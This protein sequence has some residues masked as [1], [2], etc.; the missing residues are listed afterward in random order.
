MIALL[1]L[2]S[3]SAP[4]AVNSTGSPTFAPKGGLMYSSNALIATDSSG[5]KQAFVSGGIGVDAF[6]P[7][8]HKGLDKLDVVEKEASYDIVDA[9][10]ALLG[11]G[12][13]LAP[14]GK[15]LFAL[16][17]LDKFLIGSHKFKFVFKSTVPMFKNVVDT[18]GGA[19]SATPTGELDVPKRDGERAYH[20][21][22]PTSAVPHLAGGA[23]LV[24]GRGFD[25]TG[26]M[27]LKQTAMWVNLSTW[28]GAGSEMVVALNSS[29]SMPYAF[30]G[31]AVHAVGSSVYVVGG[32]TDTNLG[33]V[34]TACHQLDLAK[35]D[36]NEVTGAAARAT[37]AGRA[38]QRPRAAS[39]LPPRPSSVTRLS[40]PA[41]A[42]TRTA[43]RPTCSSTTRRPTRG[44]K[45]HHS[46][47]RASAAPPRLPPTA[48]A[49]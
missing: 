46:N 30:Q 26:D 45:P 32:E 7:I 10:T 33:S 20:G 34:S 44:P 29:A 11:S 36:V 23:L 40:S 5:F 4:L 15:T 48:L 19:Q 41:G 9:Q 25:S 38:V 39:P 22:V 35:L 21:A 49:R 24:G 14:D 47:R 1:H 37:H 27:H 2:L 17:G 28:Y 12:L 42:P 13:V 16:C 8:F 31:A 3:V 43:S 6:E 18:S